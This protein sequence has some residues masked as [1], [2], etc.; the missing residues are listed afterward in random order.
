MGSEMELLLLL[1][2]DLA[3]DLP[4]ETAKK[5]EEAVLRYVGHRESALEH[6]E[7][8]NTALA[9]KIEEL[10]R[11][12]I[13]A[14]HIPRPPRF[15]VDEPEDDDEDLPE[16][17]PVDYAELYVREDAFRKL[18][19]H[20]SSMGKRNLEA[21]GFLMGDYY[22]YEGYTYT[23]VK[24]VVTAKL[25]SSAVSVRISDFTPMFAELDKLAKEGKDYILV[26]WYHSHPGMTCF[27]SGIDISTQKRMFREKY[28]VAVVADPHNRELRAFKLDPLREYVE[29]SYAVFG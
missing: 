15:P 5:L 28:H 3:K 19:G 27:L 16:L 29:V 7:G 11:K 4:S 26:G 12:L 2:R 1:I 9:R 25:D 14:E 10:E 18:L 22:R 8:K 21:L 20:C 17:I 23:V 6:M 13:L 24:D